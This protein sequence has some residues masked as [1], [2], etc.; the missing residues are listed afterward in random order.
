M[1]RIISKKIIVLMA[2]C[3]MAS[4]TLTAQEIMSGKYKKVLAIGAHPDDIEFMCSGT[5]MSLKAQGCEVVAVYFTQGEAGIR[6]RSH[7]EAKT[8]RHQECLDACRIMGVR[9][10]FLSQ[11]DGNSEINK[12]R[13]AEM[14][15]LIDEEKPD[16]VITHWPIDRHRDHRNCSILVQD[17]WRQC[18]QNFDLFYAEVDSGSNTSNFTP[19]CYVDITS[20]IERKEQAISAHKSQVYKDWRKRGNT[21]EAMRGYEYHCQY[22]EA[23]VKQQ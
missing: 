3:L 22:A 13:Y 1:P 7:E 5:M 10:V 17:S 19:T 12:E 23:F 18:G 6:G 14:K 11:T 20:F 21:M 2:L 15:A 16:M 9:P 4:F 8:I